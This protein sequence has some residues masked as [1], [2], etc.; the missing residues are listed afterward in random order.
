MWCSVRGGREGRGETNL[1]HH[2]A[3]GDGPA[4]LTRVALLQEEG[5]CLGGHE[6]EHRLGG[7]NHR[8]NVTLSVARVDGQ[9]RERADLLLHF[10]FLS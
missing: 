10:K 7:H 4:H 9:S 2:A 1:L 8:G 3:V 5:A 6:R